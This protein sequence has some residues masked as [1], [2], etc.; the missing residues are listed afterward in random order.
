MTRSPNA[1]QARNGPAFAAPGTALVFA[2]LLVFS[3]LSAASPALGALAAAQGTDLWGG[4]GAKGGGVPPAYFDTTIYISGTGAATGTV[5]FLAGGSLVETVAFSLPGRGTVTVLTPA[6]LLGMGAFLYHVRADAVVNAWSE[7]YNETSSG[8]YGVSLAAFTASE[9]LIPGDEAA[10]GGADASTSLASGRAR[11]NV[12]VLCNP[13]A[14]QS[15][16]IEVAAFDAGDLLGTGPVTAVPGSAA[17]G[18]LA[19]LVP[20][21]AG[22]ANLAVRIRVLS[23][24]GQPYI[25]RNYNS[26]SDAFGLPLVVTRGAFSTAPSVTSFTIAPSTGCPPQTVTATWTTVGATKVT[27]SGAAGDLPP[28]GSTTFPVFT[29]SDVVLTAYAISG[30]TTTATRKVTLLPPTDP[31]TPT[32]ATA[33]VVPGSIVTGSIPF[34]SGVVTVTFDQHG[35]TGSSFVLSGQQFTYTAGSVAGSDVVRLTVQGTCGPAS[36]FFRATVTAPGDPAISSFTANP[37]SGCSP[38]D[39]I[40]S[41]ATQNVKYVDIDPL[42]PHFT[43][44]PNGETGATISANTTFTLTAYGFGGYSQPTPTATVSVTVDTQTFTPILSTNNVVLPVNTGVLITISGVPDLTRIHRV[45]VH[46]ESGA[47]VNTGGTPGVWGYTAGFRPGNDII[48]FFYTNGCGP[49]YSEF[50]ATVFQP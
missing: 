10:G 25:I 27:I 38:A 9:F 39:I 2:L 6:S 15:C 33:T 49:A 41:W 40:L 32:P 43:L 35:S 34:S 36:A 29:T 23:G 3:L 45:Y 18:S 1:S 4:P 11:T 42:P 24:S 21:A 20:A 30:A 28:S 12:G 14:A 48:R 46:N 44:G 8:R 17:Q 26:T 16:M 5:D 37:M 31:P 50:H 47:I 19:D 13:G 7:T 22:R